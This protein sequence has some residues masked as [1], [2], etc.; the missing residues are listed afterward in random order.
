MALVSIPGGLWIPRVYEALGFSSF[1]LDAAGEKFAVIGVAPKTGNLDSFE[2]C[3]G[4]VTQAPV[5][6]L[7]CSFQDL[8]LTTG[9]PDGT[10]DQS[11]TVTAGLT[12]G[13]WVAPG[14]F[15]AV[16]GVTK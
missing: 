6:G 8:D 13:A 1:L 14:T 5:N 7:L 15:S 3:L 11:K 2:F 9:H 16:R 12:T 10:A 4:T